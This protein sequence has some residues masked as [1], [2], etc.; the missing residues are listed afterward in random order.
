[1]FIKIYKHFHQVLRFMLHAVNLVKSKHREGPVSSPLQHPE[2]SDV[3]PN[4]SG[5]GP[6]RTW[7]HHCRFTQNLSAEMGEMKELSQ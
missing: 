4:V 1:M 7:A 3:S 5:L 6:F 2:P